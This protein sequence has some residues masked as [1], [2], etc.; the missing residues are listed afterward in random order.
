M[1]PLVVCATAAEPLFAQLVGSHEPFR[2]TEKTRKRV[3]KKTSLLQFSY[4]NFL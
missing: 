1:R 4:I 2:A 3:F